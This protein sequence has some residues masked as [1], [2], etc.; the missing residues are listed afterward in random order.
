MTVLC[1]SV[2]SVALAEPEPG[3]TVHHHVDDNP[4]PKLH[5]MIEPVYPDSAREKGICGT[6][7]VEVLIDKQGIPQA[8]N[9]LRGD[10]M[11]ASTVSDA[12]QQWRWLPYRLNRQAVAVE[13]TI[14]VNFEPCMVQD[15]V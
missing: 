12:I 9:A 6:V 8:V 4:A 13:T 10:P 3:H 5:R 14:A 1:V 2:A 11:L 15:P 7:I